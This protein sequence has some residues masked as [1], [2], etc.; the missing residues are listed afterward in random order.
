MK[1]RQGDLF[2]RSLSRKPIEKQLEA[3]TQMG[4]TGIY[5]D[6]RGFKDQADSLIAQ[7]SV[8]LGG[9]PS[10]QRDDGQVVFFQIPAHMAPET[11]SQNDF[12][13]ER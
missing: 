4:F 7:L 3:I 11:P 10:L 6:R 2:Y 8:L 1:G 9:G 5:I 13:A 12:G